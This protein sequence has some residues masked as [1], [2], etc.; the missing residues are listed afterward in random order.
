MMEHPLNLF[1]A[2][3]AFQSSVKSF[4]KAPVQFAVGSEGW[5]MQQGLSSASK[6]SAPATPT[7]PPPKWEF[8][9]NPKDQAPNY[10]LGTAQQWTNVPQSQPWMSSPVNSGEGPQP[11]RMDWLMQYAQWAD[12]MGRGY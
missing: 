9:P 3:P 4:N 5:R 7:P 8:K 11:P 6:P 12:P 2:W 1:G 10:N